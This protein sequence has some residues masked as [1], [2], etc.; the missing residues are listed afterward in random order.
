LKQPDYI[1]CRELIGFIA[2]YLD[3]ALSSEVV[4]EFERHLAVCPS[5]VAYLDSYR[6]TIRL[7]QM[8]TV[9]SDEPASGT[10]PEGLLNAIRAVLGRSA[11]PPSRQE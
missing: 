2:D 7:G 5:C 1:T 3:G 9:P 10:V 8:A 4:H 11:S 6:K